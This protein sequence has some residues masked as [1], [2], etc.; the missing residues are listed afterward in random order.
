MAGPLPA[1]AAAG[2]AVLMSDDAI[3]RK[4]PEVGRG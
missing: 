1:A 3:R 4:N 2:E